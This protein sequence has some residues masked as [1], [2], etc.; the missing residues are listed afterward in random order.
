MATRFKSILTGAALA[1]GIASSGCI[2]Q[3]CLDT[4]LLNEPQV[5]IESEFSERIRTIN[6]TMEARNYSYDYRGEHAY[7][8]N[9]RLICKPNID[10]NCLEGYEYEFFI[11]Y[12]S[13][14][15]ERTGLYSE[16]R[17][18]F[19]ESIAID[20]ELNPDAEGGSIECIVWSPACTTN[21]Y[22]YRDEEGITRIFTFEYRPRTLVGTATAEIGMSAVC[23][24]PLAPFRPVDE[25]EWQTEEQ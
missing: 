9:L 11:N 19:R 7:G 16:N 20:T 3:D 23:P 21:G 2:Q 1:A 4:Y 15:G 18:G 25:S 22:F 8:E 12:V 13:P 6:L 10:N 14:D 24:A 17:G 5:S